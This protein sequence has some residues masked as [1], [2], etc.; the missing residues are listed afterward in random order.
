VSPTAAFYNH[1]VTG[2]SSVYQG[3]VPGAGCGYLSNPP[4]GYN[5]AYT[6]GIS[7]ANV[8]RGE[9]CG[10]C[11]QVLSVTEASNNPI[12]FVNPPFYVMINNFGPTPSDHWFDFSNNAAPIGGNWNLEWVAVQCPVTEPIQWQFLVGSNQWYLQI[13]PVYQSINIAHL[14]VMDTTGTYQPM[15]RISSAQAFSGLWGYSGAAYPPS[16]KAI[17]VDGQVIVDSVNIDLSSPLTTS[18]IYMGTNPTQFGQIQLP[19]VNAPPNCD[20]PPSINSK[21]TAPVTSSSTAKP[22]NQPVQP[23]NQPAQPTNQPAH[24]TNN[25]GGDGLSGGEIVGIVIG[26]SFGAALIMAG[27]LLVLIAAGVLLFF[28]ARRRRNAVAGGD[29]NRMEE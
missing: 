5:V 28:M 6:V 14:C 11:A 20:A 15:K 21:I 22:T 4:A 7:D 25:N 13:L 17:S 27:L 3:W 29:Y 16:F 10:M 24:P 18:A 26:S 2:L 8:Y 23:T 1:Q 9:V 12:P 19:I